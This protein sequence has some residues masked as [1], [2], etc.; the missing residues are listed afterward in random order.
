MP[1][2]SPV[3]GA[4]PNVTTAPRSAP[5]RHGSRALANEFPMIALPSVKSQRWLRLTATSKTVHV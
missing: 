3:A 5:I 1:S 2:I 4:S